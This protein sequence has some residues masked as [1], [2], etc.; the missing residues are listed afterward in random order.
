MEFL[1]ESLYEHIALQAAINHI[2]PCAEISIVKPKTSQNAAYGTQTGSSTVG[3]GL[4]FTCVRRTPVAPENVTKVLTWGIPTQQGLGSPL[5]LSEISHYVLEYNDQ[6]IIIPK[7]QTTYTINGLSS[8]AIT[9]TM[10]T[11]DTDGLKSEPI[12]TEG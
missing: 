9:F 2:L 7:D 6:S 8:K 10:W 4:N 11:V 5:L 1:D 12:T 3:A